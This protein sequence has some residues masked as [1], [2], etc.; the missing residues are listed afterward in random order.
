MTDDGFKEL[1]SLK[2]LAHL[3]IVDC[4]FSN[5]GLKHLAELDLVS[6]NLHHTRVT[7]AGMKHLLGMKKLSILNVNAEGV[8]DAGLMKLAKIKTLTSV[9]VRRS[10]RVTDAG[11]AKLKKALPKCRVERAGF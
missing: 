9:T 10:A 7:D 4:E 5:A 8:T 3:S 11:I 6:L 2:T 1:A